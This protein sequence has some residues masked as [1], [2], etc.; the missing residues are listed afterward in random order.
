MKNFW[1]ILMMAM[2]V[3][4]DETEGGGGSGGEPSGEP[5]PVPAT[6]PTS[7]DNGG[8]NVTLSKAELAELVA[9]IQE[10]AQEKAIN[11]AVTD[12]SSR[13][14]GFDIKK[15][16]EY[17]NELHKTDPK[18]AESLNNP[19]GW[20]LTW[21]REL[22]TKAVKADEVNGGRNVSVDSDIGDL[23][24]KINSGN[25]SIDDHTELFMKYA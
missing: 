17:L 18:K 25:G 9:P 19:Q 5:A 15:V 21:M 24:K 4:F 8:E 14:E 2:M 3:S 1:R 12:I 22:A 6:Q 11:T 20:E 13:H 16:G 10:Y 23:I 7:A